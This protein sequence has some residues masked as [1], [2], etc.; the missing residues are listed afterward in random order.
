MQ[1]MM[2][3]L[4]NIIF[5]LAICIMTSS[6]S[7]AFT[8]QLDDGSGESSL[9]CGNCGTIW[10]NAFQT[11][12]SGTLITDIDIAFGHNGN[13]D[14]PPDG[15]PISVFLWED[16]TND[17]DPTDAI[18][19]ATVSGTVQSSHTDTF[20]NFVLP[21]AIS[22]T[23]NEW[24]FVGFQSTDF[25]VS[26][27]TTSNAGQSWI[28]AWNAGEVPDPDN[29]LSASAALGEAGSLGFSGNFLIRANAT[30]ALVLAPVPALSEWSLLL[31]V[32][33]L[34][35]IGVRR[36]GIRIKD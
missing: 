3:K 9:G 4:A 2:K 22:L 20:I 21:T 15:T 12:P 25:A 11:V 23:E 5:F 10:L 29:L 14:G 7:A 27:D 16:P 31:L 19:V 34:G 6:A 17:G 32:L 8:Y 36:N 28:A 18:V 13:S 1:Y 33:L 30:T 24:F 26:R 35:F